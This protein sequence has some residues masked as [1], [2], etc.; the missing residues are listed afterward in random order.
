M[1]EQLADP[2]AAVVREVCVWYR[3][4]SVPSRQWDRVIREGGGH[5][6]FQPELRPDFERLTAQVS[7][8]LNALPAFDAL[9]QRVSADP[10]LA[11][12]LL[13]GPGGA[14][15]ADEAARRQR[16]W[17]AVVG[18]FL[19]RYFDRD[20][21]QGRLYTT[22]G[23]RFD[24]TSFDATL[25]QADAD[26][27]AAR[28]TTTLTM[29][30]PLVHLRLADDIDTLDVA[31]GITLRRVTPEEI[32]QW[33][34]SVYF[35]YFRHGRSWMEM[36]ELLGLTCAIDIRFQDPP[37]PPSLS[38]TPPGA[39]PS[40]YLWTVRY[41][42]LSAVRLLTDA[43]IFES[44]SLHTS[45]D[46]LNDQVGMNPGTAPYPL[47][48]RPVTLDSSQ[49][50]ALRTLCTQLGTSPNAAKAAF[51]LRHWEG[52]MDRL[53]PADMLIDYWIAL[54]SL[55]TPDGTTEL[56]FRASL[57]IAAFLG[58]D[59]AEREKLY[60]DMRD[61]YNLRSSIVH[62]DPPKGDLETL[63][64]VTRA[65]V[66]RTLRKILA[67]SRRFDPTRIEADLLRTAKT[68]HLRLA[69]A[70][71]LRPRTARAGHDDGH[72]SE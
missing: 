61:S 31:P 34:N 23:L 63:T 26:L 28:G 5:T 47:G 10:T 2:F 49:A 59:G 3:G 44:F 52:A 15:L 41:R 21:D 53:Q 36:S 70:G 7:A 12:R 20:T 17:S 16:L 29:I 25:R 40:M 27:Q 18:P 19:A 42:I 65:C 58:Q 13:S 54:E 9:E 39:P 46:L 35:V 71:R 72:D 67:S 6:R 4:Q 33:Y 24:A 38:G 1:I 56:K 51:A 11:T 37:P 66:G 62:G 69:R 30:T 55:F 57:R 64:T 50:A 45:R 60:K 48:G 43:Q 8:Q 14:P 32:E 68:G 22:R